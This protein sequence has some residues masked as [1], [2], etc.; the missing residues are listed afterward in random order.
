M[1]RRY[2]GEILHVIYRILFLL[3][4]EQRGMM[5]RPRL[6]L[7]REPTAIAGLRA[8]A[9]GDIPREDDFTDLW[10]GLKVTFRMVREGAPEL[11]VFGYDG[12]LFEDDGA[13]SAR[14]RTPHDHPQQRPAARH[15]RPDPHRARGRA[16]AHLLRRP[17]RGGAGLHLREPARLY[18]A[19]VDDRAEEV[20]WP[21]DPGQHLLPRPARLGAQDH[22]LLLHPSLAG[23]RADQER[24]AAGGA[25]PAGGGRTARDRGGDH[26]RGDGGPAD[27]LCR[28]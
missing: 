5:P 14:W 24:A 8:R 4:A 1:C 11:G 3:F 27:R 12:M 7:C 2:Y 6:A 13:T 20:R 17:G 9:E 16:A 15:P 25:R 19:R 10:E 26:R 28:R 21:R 18:P 23:Q 22:R